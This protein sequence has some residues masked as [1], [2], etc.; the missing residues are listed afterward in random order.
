MHRLLRLPLVLRPRE[1]RRRNVARDARGAHPGEARPDRC[2]PCHRSLRV[3]SGRCGRGGPRARSARACDRSLRRPR[4]PPHRMHVR[5]WGARRSRAGD[6]SDDGAPSR[7][8]SPGR[9]V[10]RAAATPGRRRQRI[11]A[12]SGDLRGRRRPKGA[13]DGRRLRLRAGASRPLSGARREA[14]RG[15]GAPRGARGARA[16][17]AREG[18]GR[19]RRAGQMARPLSARPGARRLRGTARRPDAGAR[20]GAGRVRHAEGESQL[21]G[22][23][24][25]PPCDD[26]GDGAHDRRNANRRA[27]ARRGRPRSDRLRTAEPSFAEKGPRTRGRGAF[28]SPSVGRRPRHV[29]RAHASSARGDLPAGDPRAP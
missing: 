16:R 26:A 21:L 27:R 28:D 24:R 14:P 7:S 12:A 19:R 23:R 3:A 15:S 29:D 20:S 10:L 17:I 11:H 5:P 1:R 2:A 22:G 6:R 9:G 18:D 13:R 8:R 4:R 25:A